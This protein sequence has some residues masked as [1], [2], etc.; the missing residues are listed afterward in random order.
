MDDKQFDAL[1]RRYGPQAVAF[2]E[3]LSG[4][5]WQRAHRTALGMGFN[6][7]EAA[8]IA[9]T[10]SGAAARGMASAC[11]AA[12]RLRELGVHH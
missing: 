6:P 1:A 10:A 2:V 4:E 12:T 9:R 5:F 7:A 8:D 3:Y 11:Q